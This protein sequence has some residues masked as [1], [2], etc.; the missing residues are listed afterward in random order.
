MRK[1]SK[2]G[3]RPSTAG[4][5]A[6]RANVEYSVFLFLI[7][8][9][10]VVVAIHFCSSSSSYVDPSLTCPSSSLPPTA[11]S[12]YLPQAWNETVGAGPDWAAEASSRLGTTTD[13]QYAIDG[14]S[15]W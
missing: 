5:I 7:S 11:D 13:P 3:F 9:F 15:D 2:R 14:N 8:P 4:K 1:T 6:S 10:S 12:P